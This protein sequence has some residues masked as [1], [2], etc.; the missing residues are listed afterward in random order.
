VPYAA[1]NY[2]AYD[3]LKKMFNTNEV[4]NIPTLLI[5]S[6]AAGAMS[7]SATFRSLASRCKLELSATGRFTRTCFMLSSAFFKRGKV[8]E[9]PEKFLEL[10]T[11]ASLLS[12]YQSCPSFP[13]ISQSSCIGLG[14]LFFSGKLAWT[15][16]CGRILPISL[17]ENRSE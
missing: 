3:T 10:S 13:T 7:S 16:F 14:S 11:S 2:F 12:T 4:G 15:E 8:K 17:N 5:G 9:K 6:S 1:T